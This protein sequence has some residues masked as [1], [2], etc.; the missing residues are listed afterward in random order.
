MAAPITDSTDITQP[1]N[2]IFQQTMLK[3]ARALCP[4]FMGTMPAMI[5][6]HR[7]TT[8]AKWRRYENVAPTTTPLAELTGN[9]ALPVRD[10]IVPTITDITSTVQKYGQYFLINETVDL[11]LFSTETDQLV[12]VLGISAGRS[13]NFL[14]RNEFEDNSTQFFSNGASV[15]AVN[16]V[17]DSTAIR[18]A[19]NFLDRN[20]AMKFTPMTLGSTNIATTPIR[21][22]YWGIC[23]VDV[24]E[25]IR[26]L[27]KFISVEKYAGQ[28]VT[29]SGEFGTVDGV[30]FISTSDASIDLGGGATGGTNVRETSTNADVYQV[31]IYGEEAVGSLGFGTAH[32]KEIYTAGDKLP[33]VQM[34]THAKGSSGI[35][36]PLDEL[37]TIGW[38]SWHASQVLNVLWT[39][40]INCAATDL[41]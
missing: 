10:S 21:P 3:Q 11:V 33:A 5:S 31:I 37:Q 15:A 16:T 24:E 12:K 4:Y 41:S 30:R 1:V 32:T 20:V 7:G 36:D 9:L 29:A 14:Q 34:I 39:T 19:T 25:D 40:A 27:A 2:V 38:K 28:T 23:H 35:A 8:T 18:R 6:T 22:A 26:D 17:I 13:L